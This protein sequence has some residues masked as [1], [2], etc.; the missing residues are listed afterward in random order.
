MRVNGRTQQRGEG[1]RQRRREDGEKRNAAWQALT[2]GQQL[3]SLMVRRG[4]SKRQVTK[5]RSVA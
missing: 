4:N 1:A 2:P 5:L 3:A